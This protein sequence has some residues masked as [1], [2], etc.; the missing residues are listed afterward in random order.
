MYEELHKQAK[1]KVEAKMAFYV[2][3]VILTSVSIIL[4]VLSFFMQYPASFW[5]RFPILVFAL[6]LGVFYVAVFGLPHSGALSKEWQ[7][8]EI[9]K[10]V[11][12]LY[13]EKRAALPPPEELSEEDRLELKE[14]ERL[15]Q[16]WE[17]GDDLV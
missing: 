1:K 12:R 4:L 3:A 9:E 2:L 5:L 6:F 7:E 14:L 10:E 8:E 13:R 16:K 15:K 17:W 11:A